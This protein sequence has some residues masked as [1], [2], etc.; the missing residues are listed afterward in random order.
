LVILINYLNHFFDYVRAEK[1]YAENTIINYKSDIDQYLQDAEVSTPSDI[2]KQN[3]RTFL[4][5]LE[6]KDI[7]ARSRNRKLAA[8]KLLC[9]FLK[10]EGIIKSD[11]SLEIEYAKI[12]KH[13]PVIF[14]ES[15]MNGVID[16]AADKYRDKA[17][18]ELLYGIGVRVTE[19]VG[20]KVTDI[21][22][23][24]MTAKV[25]GKWRKERIVPMNTSSANAIITHLKNRKVD[26]EFLFASPYD[27][28]VPITARTARNVVYKYGDKTKLSNISPHKFRHSCA[29]HLHQHGMDIRDVQEMLG[30]AD[31]SSTTIYTH[32]ALNTLSRNYHSAHPRG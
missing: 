10:A 29:T 8:V 31:I 20:I 26:S 3:I 25:F 27:A 12:E 19:L 6:Q 16:S 9:K 30:H 4:S 22:L 13:L 24:N 17:I 5:R 32:V 11:P 23:S 1:N 21:D 7:Q 2:T 28:T 15:E 14:S 18:L